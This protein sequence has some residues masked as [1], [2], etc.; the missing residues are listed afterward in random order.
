MYRVFEELAEKSRQEG[1]EE[2]KEE[3]LLDAVQ[4]L[5]KNL[6]LT[7]EQAMELLD[8]PSVGH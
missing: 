2:G 7:A 3:G 1:R 4:A 8:I 6:E 5:M